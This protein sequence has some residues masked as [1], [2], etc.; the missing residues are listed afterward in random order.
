MLCI[1]VD[2]PRLDASVLRLLLDADDGTH[3]CVVA[4][5]EGA[6]EPLCAIW[7]PSAAPAL[8]GAFESPMRALV[9]ALHASVV[10]VLDPGALL[11]VNTPEDLA[12]AACRPR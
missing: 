9:G 11:N 2:L 6:V 12:R 10:E 8:A 1:A 7:H 3:A 4:R 5:A